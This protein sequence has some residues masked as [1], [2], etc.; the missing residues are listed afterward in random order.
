MEIMNA[1]ERLHALVE[2]GKYLSVPSET[3]A[4]VMEKTL[5]YNAWFTLENQENAIQAIAASFLSANNLHAWLDAYGMPDPATPQTVGLVMAGNLPL[6]G[7]HDVLCVFAAGHRAQIKL[8][9]KDAHLLPH[10]LEKL[11]EID[12]RAAGYFEYTERLSGFNAV[13]ATGSNNSAR[14]FETY[15][16]AYP[17]IIRKNRNGVAV[18]SGKETV[19][20]LRALGQDIFQYY[21]LGCRNVS[22]IYVPQGYD[23]QALLE[24]LHDTYKEVILNAKYK[25]NFDY[26]YALYLINKVEF[27]MNGCLLLTENDAIASRIAG[28]HYA[29]YAHINAVEQE[30]L[31]RKEEIQCV[32]A[33]PG[34]LQQPTIRFGQTQSPSL[35]DYP[36]GADTMQFLVSLISG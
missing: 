26:N 31:H 28:L 32:V 8:S 27:K 35:R 15:F 34:L 14:Y 19:E 2:L 13:I 23:F 3:R 20:D 4:A 24:I 22:K 1:Q 36:D 6:V 5:Y 21:G 11:T 17:H 10:L 29:Y 16:G 30:L 7:F 18:L 33:L 25:H 9:E 12:A